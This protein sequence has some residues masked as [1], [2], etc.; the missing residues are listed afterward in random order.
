M[1]KIV[2]KFL[3]SIYLFGV[4]SSYYIMSNIIHAM[5]STGAENRIEIA[6]SLI[7]SLA[8]PIVMIFQFK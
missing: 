1:K 8:W 4:G 3:I 5:D 7:L 6:M 2:Y